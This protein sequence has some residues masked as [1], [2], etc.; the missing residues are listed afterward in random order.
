M[1]KGHRQ[2]VGG[3]RMLYLL[4]TLFLQS[5]QEGATPLESSILSMRKQLPHHLGKNSQRFSLKVEAGYTTKKSINYVKP[6]KLLFLGR[7][8]LQGHWKWCSR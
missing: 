1:H 8:L 6:Y 3:W 2:G 7:A 4:F 5:V